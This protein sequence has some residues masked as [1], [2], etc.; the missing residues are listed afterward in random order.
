M[1]ARIL[2]TLVL[3][4]A[5]QT[6][7]Q[8]TNKPVLARR[9]IGS[10]FAPNGFD[11]NDNAQ[12]VVDSYLPDPC[13]KVGP[14]GAKVDRVRK[15]IRLEQSVFFYPGMVCP[16]V[17]VPF[18]MVYNLGILDAGT[19][20]IRDGGND[21]PV[22]SIVI[23][24]ARNLGPDDYFYAPVG[25]ATIDFQTNEIVVEGTFNNDC[26]QL[27]QLKIQIDP[28]NVLLVLP[29]LKTWQESGRCKAGNFPFKFKTPLPNLAPARY[30]M[31][32]RSM[33]GLSI[34]KVFQIYR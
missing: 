33:N 23:R 29:I 34:N 9:P 4:T 24:Q 21:N 15:I 12:V 10:V 14:H 7:A 20:Q 1:I 25:G 11:S 6:Q 17:I 8:Q 13:Y 27:D 19:Y 30:L 28:R 31:H 16:A 5:V 26:L 3:M 32:V 22:G 2:V 18:A